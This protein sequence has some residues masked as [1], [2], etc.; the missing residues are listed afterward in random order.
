M[1]D[2]HSRGISRRDFL[3]RGGLGAGAVLLLYADGSGPGGRRFSGLLT[4]AHP[5]PA[6]HK[7]PPPTGFSRSFYRRDDFIALS[8]TFVNLVVAADGSTLTRPGTAPPDAPSVVVV[9]FPPQSVLEEG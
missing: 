2:G 4:S 8:F 7:P 9:E 5:G 6:S 1:G 3:K